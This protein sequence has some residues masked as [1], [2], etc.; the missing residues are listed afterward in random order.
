MVIV[1]VSVA[2]SLDRDDRDEVLHTY[3][4]ARTY[5][6][7]AVSSDSDI[8][9]KVGANVLKEKGNAV[10]SAVA[11][12][13]CLGVINLHSCG[14]GGGG[15]MVAYMRETKEYIIYDFREEAPSQASENMYVKSNKTSKYGIYSIILFICLNIINRN[16]LMPI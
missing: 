1:A 15:F 10:D 13:F 7:G 2:L 3:T 11:T 6:N 4:K 5:K 8:C 16:M 12:I 14:I 9:S